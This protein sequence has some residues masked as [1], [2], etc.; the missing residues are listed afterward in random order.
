MKA[1]KIKG[2]SSK[3]KQTLKKPKKEQKHLTLP[4]VVA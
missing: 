2:Y 3:I 1:I 4:M